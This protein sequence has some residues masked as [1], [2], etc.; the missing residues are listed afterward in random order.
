[1]RTLVIS[2]VAGAVVCIVLYL[3][4][5]TTHSVYAKALAEAPPTELHLQN[6]TV[7]NCTY[8][9]G[10]WFTDDVNC[11]GVIYSPSAW[12]YHR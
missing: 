4:M 12:D 2:I 10:R 7:I 8:F 1:M 9:A 5:T 3:I 6:G 11:D